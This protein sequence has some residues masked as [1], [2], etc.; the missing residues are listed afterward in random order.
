[1]SAKSPRDIPWSS[2]LQQILLGLRIQLA[3]A[4]LAHSQRKCAALT[5]KLHR[6]NAN[7]AEWNLIGMRLEKALAKKHA[8]QL[9][10]EL[11]LKRVNHAEIELV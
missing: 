9:K 5:A 1:L 3:K 10:L 11:L 6:K 2:D 7:V 4:M 8:L